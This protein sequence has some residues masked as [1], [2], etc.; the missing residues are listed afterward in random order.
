MNKATIAITRLL[1][2]SNQDRVPG[3]EHCAAAESGLG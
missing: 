1:D 3:E 2:C